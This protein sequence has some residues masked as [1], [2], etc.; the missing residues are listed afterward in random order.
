[1]LTDWTDE[2]PERVFARL[3]KQSDYYNFEP[4]HARRFMRDGAASG[5]GATLADAARVG[6]DADERRPI[7]PT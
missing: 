7:S 6:R 3:K 4:A 1:M 2:D 5:L